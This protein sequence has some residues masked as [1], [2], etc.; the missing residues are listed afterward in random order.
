MELKALIIKIIYQVH[1]SW[2]HASLRE[3]HIDI[4]IQGSFFVIRKK[5]K[6]VVSLILSHSN[7]P[8][9][10]IER[11]D[12]GVIPRVID[13]VYKKLSYIETREEMDR[14]HLALDVNLNPQYYAQTGW[15]FKMSLTG[16]TEHDMNEVS[17]PLDPL[18]S[19]FCLLE[20]DF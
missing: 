11:R 10:F 16:S 9:Q 4:S 5:S 19:A 18:L 7:F 8:L 14:F 20:T 2:Y 6:L 1:L 12:F 3:T 17:F 13:T 15:I